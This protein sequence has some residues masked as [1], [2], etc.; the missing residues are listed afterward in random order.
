M[1][2]QPTNEQSAVCQ[3]QA[4]HVFLSSSLWEMKSSGAR[5]AKV[6]NPLPFPLCEIP[7]PSPEV[8]SHLQVIK[9]NEAPSGHILEVVLGKKKDAIL[10]ALDLVDVITAIDLK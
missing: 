1:V 9:Y 5:V 8:R 2:L 3:Q 10:Q 4:V 7:F 6:S